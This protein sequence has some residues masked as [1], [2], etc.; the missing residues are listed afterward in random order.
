[1]LRGVCITTL[2]GIMAESDSGTY[3][4]PVKPI[5]SVLWGVKVSS[6]LGS[7]EIITVSVR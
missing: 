1:M 3:I 4:R 2:R 5:D 7:L 6:M